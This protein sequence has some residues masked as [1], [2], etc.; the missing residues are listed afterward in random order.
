MFDRIRKFTPLAGLAL[1]VVLATVVSPASCDMVQG[2]D[3]KWTPWPENAPQPLNTD[4]P[5]ADALA[6]SEDTKITEATYET[7]KLSKGGSRPAALVAQLASF[8]ALRNETYTQAMNDA[9]SGLFVE[10]SEGFRAAAGELKDFAKQDALYR[11]MLAAGQTGDAGRAT[12]AAD[13]LLTAFPKSFYLCDAQILKAKIA[14]IKGDLAA[15]GAALDAVKNAAGMNVRDSYRAQHMKVSLTLELQRK[16]EQAASEYRVLIGSMER[17]KDAAAVVVSKQ[18]CQVGLGNCLLALRKDKEARTFFVQATESRDADVLAGAYNG[19]GDVALTEARAL[20]DAKQLAE[21]KAKLENEAI[22][23]YLRVSLKYRNDVT[24][25]SVVL[26]AMENQAAVFIALFDMSGGK[27][28]E[29]AD[30]ACRTYAELVRM[31]PEG[32]AQRR[33]IGRAYQEIDKKRDACKPPTEKP[34]SGKPPLP[35]E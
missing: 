20:K 29:A 30:R 11:A 22:L 27:D 12:A 8:E 33:T 13:E 10:A 28:C 5:N 2:I 3:L 4:P 17:E 31:L 18:R 35:A 24:D 19:L 15:T 6:A 26:R 9:S 16:Y 7:V 1:F 21:A 25:T 23:H 14:A 34:A 32:S